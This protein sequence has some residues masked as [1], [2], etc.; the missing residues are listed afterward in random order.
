VKIIESYAFSSCAGLNYVRIGKNV[1][2]IAPYAFFRSSQFSYMYLPKS[3]KTIGDH[4][5]GDC[6]Y[7]T[8]VYYEG[9][10]EEFA[11]LGLTGTNAQLT[12]AKKYYNYDYSGGIY[13]AQQ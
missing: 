4:A 7:L 8:H 2:T 3:V 10:E 6:N 5:F 11:A 1:E 12:D 13:E 9:T